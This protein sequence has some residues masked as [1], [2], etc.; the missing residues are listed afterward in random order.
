MEKEKNFKIK[1][2]ALAIRIASAKKKLIPLTTW[3]KIK[4]KVCGE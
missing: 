1:P 4:A 3:E 2:L